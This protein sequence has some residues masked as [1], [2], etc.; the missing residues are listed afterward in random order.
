MM[1]MMIVVASAWPQQVA[2]AGA[3]SR[4]GASRPLARRL[5]SVRLWGPGYHHLSQ[6]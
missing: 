5:A 4:C 6:L 3:A 2:N 1:M